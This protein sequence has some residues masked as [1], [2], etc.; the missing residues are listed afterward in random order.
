L[1]LA[2]PEKRSRDALQQVIAE[3]DPVA[4]AKRKKAELDAKLEGLIF[5][6]ASGEEVSNVLVPSCLFLRAKLALSN[7]LGL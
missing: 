4:R 6:Q 1:Q 7:Y 3:Q 5:R 2:S